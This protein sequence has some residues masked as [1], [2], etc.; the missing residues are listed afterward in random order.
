MSNKNK[1][2]P[3]V[4]TQEATDLANKS[5]EKKED[6]STAL[7]FGS[8]EKNTENKEKA[9]VPEKEKA[10]ELNKKPKAEEKPAKEK[11]STRKSGGR[12]V[13]GLSC[14]VMVASVG[15]MGMTLKHDKVT[16]ETTLPAIGD[17]LAGSENIAEDTSFTEQTGIVPSVA[18]VSNGR[19][20]KMNASNVLIRAEGENGAAVPVEETDS[21][22]YDGKSLSFEKDGATYIVRMVADSYTGAPHYAE[23]QTE[24]NVTVSGMRFVGNGNVLAVI[25]TK[26]SGNE[27]DRA[28]VKAVV[29]SM[30]ENAVPA[31]TGGQISV[32]GATIGT[33][34]NDVS[35]A[36][37]QV[38]V[39]SG[40]SEIKFA[41]STYNS[42]TIAFDAVGTTSSGALVTHSDYA[43]VKGTETYLIESDDG[44]VMVFTNDGNMLLATLGLQ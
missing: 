12:F 6:F 41:P 39:K 14:A 22:Q 8:D 17:L 21:F 3:V 10:K 35:I 24:K 26:N 18:I 30:L 16:G 20:W 11:K 29:A 32:N 15:V 13:L 9:E 43:N 36:N 7:N 27:E 40:D 31:Q 44:N 23:E 37:N 25:G 5:G 19:N 33:E 42:K 4:P 1:K 38:L 28:A 34:N 2:G